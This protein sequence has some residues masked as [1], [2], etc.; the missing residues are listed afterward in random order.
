MKN[1]LAPLLFLLLC[2]GC[3]KDSG[4]GTTTNNPPPID[5]TKTTYTP[6]IKAKI[7]GKLWSAT[8]IGCTATYLT[9]TA[10]FEL[11]FTGSAAN[12]T[13]FDTS[14]IINVWDAVLAASTTPAVYLLPT[15]SAN[16]AT[17]QVAS[18]A[19]AIFATSGNFTIDTIVKRALHTSYM[20][21]TFSF[22]SDTLSV[23]EGSF[24]VAYPGY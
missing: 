4:T 6:F 18:Y 2:Y 1:A 11:Y 19:P 20:T 21:G 10:K 16:D 9:T 24:R 13:S 5:T 12:G 22:T 15:K 23:T 3:S 17:V 7:N 8:A 14:I